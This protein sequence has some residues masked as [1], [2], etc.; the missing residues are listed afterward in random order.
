[1]E[2]VFRE[3]LT[4]AGARSG[5]AYEKDPLP[6]SVWEEGCAWRNAGLRSLS[7]VGKNYRISY[8]SAH[9]S[10]QRA[11]ILAD[12]AI[13]PIPVSACTDGIVSLGD[14]QGL[15][16]LPD[17]AIGLILTSKLTMPAKAAADHLRA[18]FETHNRLAIKQADCG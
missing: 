14:K 12:L 10:G 2:I 16:V 15:P 4:W 9:I 7:D 17:Y 3:S 11:A 5:V 1:M 6:I 18:S 13:A 8:M